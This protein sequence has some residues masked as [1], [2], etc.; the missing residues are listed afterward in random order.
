MPTAGFSYDWDREFSTTD[1]EYY[2]WTQWIFLQLHARGL[3]YQAEVPVNW[4]PELGTVLANEEVIDGLSERGGFPVVRM[5]MR[6]ASLRGQ[7]RTLSFC[8]RE[9]ISNAATVVAVDA[10]DHCLR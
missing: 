1:P 9:I 10:A 2:R 8:R 7:P 4:C 5:P 3:A 6:Q